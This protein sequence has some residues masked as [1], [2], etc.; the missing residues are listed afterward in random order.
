M[1]LFLGTHTLAA[2]AGSHPAISISERVSKIKIKINLHD[3]VGEIPPLPLLLCRRG[4]RETKTI[5]IEAGD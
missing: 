2:G 1:C 4:A 5:R 3:W